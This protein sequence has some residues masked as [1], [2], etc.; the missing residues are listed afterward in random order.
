M[1]FIISWQSVGVVFLLGKNLVVCLEAEINDDH[2]EKKS[3]PP[4]QKPGSISAMEGL[5]YQGLFSSPIFYAKA[6]RNSETNGWV[7]LFMLVPS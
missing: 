3:T 5:K 4:P 1:I 2:L 6:K 7:E